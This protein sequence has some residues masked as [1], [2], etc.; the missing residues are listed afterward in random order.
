MNLEPSELQRSPRQLLHFGPA[1]AKAFT[2]H[3]PGARICLDPFHAVKLAIEALE[4]VRKDLWRQMR[5]LPS[6]RYARKFAGARWALLKNPGD[7]TE[8]QNE[9]L[10]RIKATGGAL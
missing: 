9:T 2:E 8:R 6:S 4:E 5:K 7:L 10:K 1:F 3:A